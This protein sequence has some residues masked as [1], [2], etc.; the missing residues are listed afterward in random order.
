MPKVV[1]QRKINSWLNT[2]SGYL[3]KVIPDLLPEVVTQRKIHSLGLF[4]LGFLGL[5]SHPGI[6]TGQW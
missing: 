3:K 4:Y 2:I 5:I 6:L 1:S